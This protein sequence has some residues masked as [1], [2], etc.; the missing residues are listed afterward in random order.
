M[1][2]SDYIVEYLIDKKI[3]HVFCYPGGM[4][5]HLT[6]SFSKYNKKITQHLTYNEQGAALAA[7]GYAQASGKTGVAYATSGPGATNLI[8]GICNAFFDSVPC[9]FITGQVNTSESSAGL[10]IRQRGFQETDIVSL[11]SPITKY[12][13]YADKP[14][15]IKY[16]LDKAFETANS[17]RKGP[18]LID[19][20]MD[21]LRAD[22][23]VASLE[24]FYTAKTKK[25]VDE[26][27]IAKIRSA[28]EQS[29]RPL[30]LVGNG[31]KISDQVDNLR[32]FL[33]KHQLPVVSSMLA[34]DVI[35]ERSMYYGFIGAYGCRTANFL[36]AK[37]DLLISL[38]SRLDI[39]QVGRDREKFAPGARIIRFDVDNAELN[40]KVH[41]DEIDVEI[42]I[43]KAIEVLDKLIPSNLEYKEWLSVCNTIQTELK[44]IDEMPS[45]SLM[46][47]ISN[48]FLDDTVITTDV[49]QNQVWASQSLRIKPG[50]RL[51][52]SGGHGAMGYSLPAAI[53]ACLANGRIVYSINGDGGLQMNIQELQ[54]V[55]REKLP[56]KVLLF[57]NGALGMIRHFQ[58]MYFEGNY[59]LTK[60]GNGFSNPDFEK[61]AE[62]Y[63]FRYSFIKSSKDIVESE[64]VDSVPSFIEV[65][66]NG[67]TYVKPKLEFGKPNQDQEPLIGRE[68]YN[69]LMSI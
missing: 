20:P 1:K 17:G 15:K 36:A 9:V 58:E 46:E 23:D 54:T 30:L 67:N 2:I 26:N 22:I 40:Y 10:D 35:G 47:E 64:F 5:T 3:E 51:L 48:C 57:N 38:G 66:T 32:K 63:G 42:G 43:Q 6:D 44:G 53:G 49:G 41:E 37:C 19:I 18:C 21:I 34:V 25:E 55:I 60:E 65:R 68:K 13:V 7:C 31:V 8:T 61:I 16:Y 39:R 4:T 56:I 69:Y 50:Q 28:I 12:A 29:K 52:T 27:S 33:E 59:V 62:A 24:G 14:Y 45:T 11:V